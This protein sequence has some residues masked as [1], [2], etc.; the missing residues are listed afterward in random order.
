[1]ADFL[2]LSP[3][4]HPS[5]GEP[6]SAPE[7][8][9]IDIDHI[10]DEACDSLLDDLSSSLSSSGDSSVSSVSIV[11][12]PTK[13]GGPDVNSHVNSDGIN[14]IADSSF[15]DLNDNSRNNE[16]IDK[17]NDIANVNSHVAAI[18]SNGSNVNAEVRSNSIAS[19]VVDGASVCSNLSAVDTAGGSD[20]SNLV[21][22]SNDKD[23][24]TATNVELDAGVFN[25]S[26]AATGS[27]GNIYNV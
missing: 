15:C 19:A 16:V 26:T 13:G 22:G 24:T 10:V 1:M 11:D 25:E 2:P 4:P 21:D 12:T 14:G 23:S 17:S 9:S 3:A 18:E 6:P 8:A 7:D 20:S 5:V 27:G